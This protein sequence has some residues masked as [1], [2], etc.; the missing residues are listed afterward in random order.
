MTL[1]L[2]CYVCGRSIDD[3]FVLGSPASET[4]RPFANHI[5]EQ[6]D[7]ENYT[8]IVRMG[9]TKCHLHLRKEKH[10]GDKE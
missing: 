9:G 1:A 5:A 10:D 7:D 4:D 3:L 2:K 8:L 6:L